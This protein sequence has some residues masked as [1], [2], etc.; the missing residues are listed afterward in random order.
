M[1]S[2]KRNSH[3]FQRLT[4]QQYLYAISWLLETRALG[5]TLDLLMADVPDLVR[6]TVLTLIGNSD[7]ASLSTV[8]SLAQAAPNLG[9]SRK[10]FMKH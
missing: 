10:V 9:V 2:S 1:S 6:V 7:H 5:G 8:I 4:S 3:G